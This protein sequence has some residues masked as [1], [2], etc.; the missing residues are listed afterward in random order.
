MQFLAVVV[1]ALLAQW[2]DPTIPRYIVLPLLIGVIVLTMSRKRDRG[3]FVL[4]AVAA[5]ASA[6]LLYRCGR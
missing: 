2:L 3:Q 4:T 5:I 1:A 6:L